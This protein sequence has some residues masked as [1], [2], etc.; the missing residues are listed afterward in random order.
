MVLKM[1]LAMKKKMIFKVSMLLAN[2]NTM[3][4]I[5]NCRFPPQCSQGHLETALVKKTTTLFVA[6][7]SYLYNETTVDD[8]LALTAVKFMEDAKLYALSSN[9]LCKPW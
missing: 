1:S 6:L 5:L 8:H 2:I 3:S 9:C 4:N 7:K